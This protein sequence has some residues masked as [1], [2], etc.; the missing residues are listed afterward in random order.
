[1]PNKI[2]ASTPEEQA[3]LEEVVSL[4]AAGGM[5]LRKASA[6]FEHKTG[7]KMSHERIR[8]YADKRREPEPEGGVPV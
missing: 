7:K 3:V 5:S 2:R 8:Q 1:M 4:V 6:W